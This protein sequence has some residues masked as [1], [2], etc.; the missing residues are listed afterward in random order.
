MER[1]DNRGFSILE[2]II[3]ITIM[4]V[5]TAILAPQFLVYVEEAREAACLSNRQTFVR[6]YDIYVIEMDD[7]PFTQA[8]F[9]EDA[10]ID[11]LTVEMICPSHGDCVLK[12]DDETGRLSISCNK[13][14]A[15]I[16]KILVSFIGY[17]T[18]TPEGRA[19]ALKNA[20]NLYEAA[21][22]YIAAVVRANP[23]FKGTGAIDVNPTSNHNWNGIMLS[24]ELTAIVNPD[25][26]TFGQARVVMKQ[27][28]NKNYTI[29]DYVAIKHGNL[30]AKYE[31][32]QQETGY[33]TQM[34]GGPPNST[35]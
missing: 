20:K 21:Q 14:A 5:L 22:D 1:H 27:D 31:P 17:K 11:G 3:V 4:A 29:V 9:E 33:S 19:A 2:L 34:P 32:T 7:V 28:A 24:K 26:I 10:R 35:P 18:D 13:H 25:N 8:E 23:G 6:Y 12:I 30:W 15:F 16:P